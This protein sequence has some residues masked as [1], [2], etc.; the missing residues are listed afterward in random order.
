M[1]IFFIPGFLL[2]SGLIY[3]KKEYIKEKY[4]KWQD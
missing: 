3:Y 1:L 4:D 2:L